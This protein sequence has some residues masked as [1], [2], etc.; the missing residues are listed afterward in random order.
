MA[1][2]LGLI[3]PT[4]RF[5]LP[6]SSTAPFEK[7]RQQEPDEALLVLADDDV[8]VLH[9]ERFFL[10]FDKQH[11]RCLTMVPH[12]SYVCLRNSRV[13]MLDPVVGDLSMFLRPS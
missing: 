4:F 2:H 10:G 13:V 3:S 1:I 9:M 6:R 8:R 11:T 12:E 7:L 5:V